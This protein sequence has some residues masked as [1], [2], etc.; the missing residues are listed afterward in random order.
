MANAWMDHVKA[1]KKANPSKSLKDVLKIAAKSYK[2]EGASKKVAK[3]SKSSKK[4]MKKSAKK[5]MKKMK[6]SGKK[7][8]N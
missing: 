6:K 2:K 8:R 3:V 4:T 1:V 7:S 5:S